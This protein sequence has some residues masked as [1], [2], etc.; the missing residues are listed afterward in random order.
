MGPSLCL[1]MNI[2]S[3]TIVSARICVNLKIILKL[4]D[5]ALNR[6]EFDFSGGP[7][8][9]CF[10]KAISGAILPFM[11]SKM[12][13]WLPR[14]FI[15]GFAATMVIPAPQFIAS[16]KDDEFL[17]WLLRLIWVLTFPTCFLVMLVLKNLWKNKK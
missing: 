17:V 4:M 13:Y 2:Q 5:P 9:R 1:G 10:A 8:S 15:I 7:L 3:R 12:S 11:R 6:L 16:M 14:L